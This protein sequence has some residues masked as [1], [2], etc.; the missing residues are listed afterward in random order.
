MKEYIRDILYCLKISIY[1]FLGA[2]LI[3]AVLG[4]IYLGFNFKGII[5]WGCRVVL[6]LSVFGY[7]V[8]GISFVK[9]DLMRPLNYQ[10]KWNGYFKK[11]NLAGVILFLAIF[12]T[13]FSFAIESII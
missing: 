9:R 8:A 10:E 4:V 5:I 3:G 11:L 13:I 1:L 2:F 6:Y 12:N 7:A